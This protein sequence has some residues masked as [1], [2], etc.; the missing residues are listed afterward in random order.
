MKK[1]IVPPDEQNICLKC[2]YGIVRLSKTKP[3]GYD[4]YYTDCDCWIGYIGK[5]IGHRKTC[6]RFI[7]KKIK[8]DYIRKLQ[9]AT[10][11]KFAAEDSYSPDIQAVRA[12][13][14][15]IW[16]WL[17]KITDDKEDQKLILDIIENENWNTND[18]TFK[19]IFQKIKALGYEIVEDK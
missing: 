9:A 3:C 10:I 4:Y 1:T 7:A 2:K 16:Y 5:N 8:A 11:R 18:V 13:E 6:S 14:R 17:G 12:N 15:A 19:P